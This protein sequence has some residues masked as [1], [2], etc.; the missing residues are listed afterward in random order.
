MGVSKQDLIELEFGGSRQAAV[1]QRVQQVLANEKQWA[2][3]QTTSAGG[4]GSSTQTHAGT[5]QKYAQSP[6]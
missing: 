5:V 6:G 1:A 4:I 3:G 2:Q